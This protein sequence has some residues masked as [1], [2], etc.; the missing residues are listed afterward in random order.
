MS[1]YVDLYAI[2]SDDKTACFVCFFGEIVSVPIRGVQQKI[3]QWKLV[4]RG[5]QQKIGQLL[6]ILQLVKL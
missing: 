2:V 4:F 1:E 3:G 6:E 5:V